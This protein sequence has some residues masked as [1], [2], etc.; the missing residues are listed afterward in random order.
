MIVFE[1]HIGIVESIARVKENK[2]RGSKT[3][4]KSGVIRSNHSFE[5][6]FH[7]SG[8]TY[9]GSNRYHLIATTVSTRDLSEWMPTTRLGNLMLQSWW[10]ICTN[11][12]F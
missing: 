9:Q 12:P 8:E 6:K 2:F 10:V 7:A 4:S 11:V 5:A 1:I 3:H